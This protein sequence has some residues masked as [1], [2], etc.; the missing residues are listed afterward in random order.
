MRSE[1]ERLIKALSLVGVMYTGEDGSHNADKKTDTIV[2]PGFILLV[3]LGKEL[4]N[5]SAWDAD[6]NVDE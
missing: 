4:S 2:R 1:S 3:Y 5:G 6:K